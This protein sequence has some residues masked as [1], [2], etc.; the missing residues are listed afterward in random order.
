MYNIK[1]DEDGLIM[2]IKQLTTLVKML[3]NDELNYAE[4]NGFTALKNE[5]FAY[6]I[7]LHNDSDAKKEVSFSLDTKLKAVDIRK[8]IFCYVNNPGCTEA[9]DEYAVIE[10]CYVPDALFPFD[11]GN[12]LTLEAGETGILLVTAHMDEKNAEAG[13]YDINVDFAFDGVN[14]TK[15]F[16]LDVIDAALPEKFFMYTNWFH[17]DSISL[18]HNE[19][20]FTEKFWVLLE[21]YMK[22]ANR[23]GMNM[24]LTPIFTPALDTEIG[25]ERLTV[26][27]VDIEKLGDK[28]V[29]EFSKFRRWVALAKKCG[30]KYFEMAHLFTQWGA[31][32][33]PKI[34]VKI[35]G[36]EEKLFGWHVDA[37]DDSYRDFLHQFLPQ[38]VSVLKEL[39]IAK[40]SFFHISDEPSGDENLV[41]YL[42]CKKMVKKDLRGFRIMDA[43]SHTDYYEKGVVT[44]PVPSTGSTEEFLKYDL[45]H[46]WTY[47]CCGPARNGSNRF[48]AQHGWVTRT[49]GSQLFKFDIEGFLHWGFNFYFTCLSKQLVSPYE[50]NEFN[51]FPQGDGCIVYPYKDDAVDSLRGQLFFEALQDQR[52]LDLLATKLGRDEVIKMIE[53]IAGQEIHFMDYPHNGEFILKWRAAV[54][55]KI[56]ELF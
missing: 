9:A 48:L 35:D 45:E 31:K 34:V 24:I 29:F 19:P 26:Q 6:Q 52:A 38:L 20:V 43:L 16:K 22:A 27:L 25:S 18:M 36:K 42:K 4:F 49:F 21:K 13:I 28:Y 51:N 37:L 8:E 53:D 33:T 10:P 55:E 46:R 17:C 11:E 44:Y 54:N 41:Q 56:R 47:Y 15:T 7:A 14:I 30:M 32:C 39:R 1:K 3:Q 40:N 23:V 2:I 50:K 12:V 5:R